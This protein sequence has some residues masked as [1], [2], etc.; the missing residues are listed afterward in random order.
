MRNASEA[1]DEQLKSSEPKGSQRTNIVIL[2]VMLTALVVLVSVITLEAVKQITSLNITF[3]Q[4]QTN[5]VLLIAL[6]TTLM[7]YFALRQYRRVIGEVEDWQRATQEK[8]LRLLEAIAE[9][10][11]TEKA[12]RQSEERYA[13]AARGSNGGLWDWCL[14]T[15]EIYLSPRWDAMLGYA[16]NDGEAPSRSKSPT[17]WFERIHPDDR[18]SV[19]SQIELHRNG[20]E[21]FFESEYRLRDKDGAYRWMIGR[22]LAVR[23]AAGAPTAWPVRK[24]TSTSASRSRSSYFTTPFT[25]R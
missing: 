9:R 8:N 17:T 2:R 21:P 3:W 15:N 23:D 19:E 12:L 13:L 4:L 18:E 10:Q 16:E 11:Q 6:V 7:A 14:Q 22:G 24:T 5:A 20:N 25:T 1:V